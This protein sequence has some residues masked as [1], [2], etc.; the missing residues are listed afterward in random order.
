MPSF[1]HLD[2]D[3]ILQILAALPVIFFAITVHELSHGWAAF[4]CGDPTP[5]QQGRITLN[6]FAH[7]DPFGVFFILITVFSGFGFGWGKPVLINPANFRNPRWN[8]FWVAAAG[9]I[10]NL[11]QATVFAV[12][13][14]PLALLVLAL[15]G[16]W[17]DAVLMRFV[18]Y[19]LSF[20]IDICDIAYSSIPSGKNDIRYWTNRSNHHD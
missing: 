9:P 13:V 10:S 17:E 5:K 4:R 20:V 7:F 15:T 12:V 1:F 18:N 8:E 16:Q 11:V 14:A 6:P 3:K 2:T 19:F